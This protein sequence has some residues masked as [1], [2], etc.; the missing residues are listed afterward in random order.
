M[1]PLL[2]S[3]LSSSVP[4]TSLPIT[5]TRPTAGFSKH[6]RMHSSEVLPLPEGPISRCRPPGENASV[7]SSSA[8]VAAAPAPY[9]R[10]TR[11]TASIGSGTEH[12]RWLDREGRAYGNDRGQG[13]HQPY[14]AQHSSDEP[15]WRVHPRDG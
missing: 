12:P 10:P 2:I 7:T 11:S 14:R 13:A 8:C 4:G 3:L 5:R 1:L 15:V 6:P 9:V